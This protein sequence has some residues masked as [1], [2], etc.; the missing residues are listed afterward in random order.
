MN[1]NL[2]PE[3][4]YDNLPELIRQLTSQYKGRERDLILLSIIGVLSACLPKVHGYYDRN[5]YAPNLYILIIA[6]PASGKGVIGKPKILIQRIHHLLMQNSSTERERCKQSNIG[7][8]NNKTICPELV[9][10]ILPGNVSGSKI[11]THL[12]N[13]VFGVLIFETEADTL[14]A[15]LK[16]DWGNFSDTLRKGF[17]HETISMSRVSDDTYFE[18]TN[19]K[20]SLVLS[21]TPNQVAPLINSQENG[22]FSRFIFYYFNDASHW[23][24][25]S[26]E[27]SPIDED[28]AFYQV[29][30]LVFEL[31]NRLL[32][33]ELGIEIKLTKSQWYSF[34]EMMTNA[35][36]SLIDINKIDILPS[37]KRHGVI[38][39]RICM[40]LSMIRNHEL[41]IVDDTVYCDDR[42]FNT[43]IKI[44]KSTLDHSIIV[45]NLL[46]KGALDNIK[47]LNMRE[48]IIY[49]KL[50]NNFT[51]QDF[52][53]LG[54]QS[55]IPKRS[56]DFIIGRLLKL[57]LIL[58][59]SNGKFQKNI[60]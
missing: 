40:I 21:G 57:G 41:N 39:F 38:M 3:E 4:I 56:L 51:R 26:P 11:Y 28:C 47:K 32:K 19:P 10:K 49:S 35:V 43:A 36:Q 5:K 33:R 14:S 24:D 58:K 44:I 12:Q 8:K 55:S 16:Q 25:V 29:G 52:L 31:H 59:V 13:S 6:P 45:S 22:L 1:E 17:H 9:L 50:N 15:A 27:G 53:A 42:D 2:F 37:V 54:A 30:D 7:K 46:A 48:S 18:I 20:L 23:K 34:N 60:K